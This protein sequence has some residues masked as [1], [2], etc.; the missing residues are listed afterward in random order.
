MQFK[1][2]LACCDGVQSV[3]GVRGV[4]TVLFGQSAFIHTETSDFFAKLKSGEIQPPGTVYKGTL[5]IQTS[6]SVF[7]CL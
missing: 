2:R 5:G 6:V 4:N 1:A 7:V 3:A